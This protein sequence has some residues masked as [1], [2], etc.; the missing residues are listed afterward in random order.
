MGFPLWPT[1][2][3]IAETPAA[4]GF[5]LWP[6]LAPVAE[7]GSGIVPP[8]TL[9]GSAFANWSF[10]PLRQVQR[11]AQPATL[12]AYPTAGEPAT[13][14]TLL[15]LESDAIASAA[16]R[17]ALLEAYPLAA[18]LVLSGIGLGLNLGS[19]FALD[20]LLMGA[21]AVVL[22][23]GVR[24]DHNLRARDGGTTTI[25]VRFRWGA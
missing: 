7:A 14:E 23:V 20:P 12:A 19:Q 11:A 2:V 1:L 9:I 18:R 4:R 15:L 16:R 6:T 10:E 21:P 8:T 25:E 3:P 22:I 13:I 5:P 24:E 17:Q